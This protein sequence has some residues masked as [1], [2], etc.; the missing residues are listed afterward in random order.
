MD[1]KHNTPGEREGPGRGSGAE[2]LREMSDDQLLELLN[3][4]TAFAAHQAK[5][6]PRR[7]DGYDLALRAIT[8]V[9]ENRR[10]SWKP[11]FSPIANLCLIVKSIASNESKR[12]GEDQTTPA[13]LEIP[14]VCPSPAEDYESNEFQQKLRRAFGAVAAR[15]GF[16]GSVL[17]A[18]DDLGHW[19]PR[20]IA[21]EL[22][23]KAA[24]VYKAKRRIRKMLTTL[25]D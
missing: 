21:A 24:D 12:K 17:G 25:L 9:L 15:D 22:N 1:A 3:K 20:E 5:R 18:A 2:V 14:S 4:L 6:Y 13:E 19:K 10:R 8:G 16:L 23:I 11:E 7:L